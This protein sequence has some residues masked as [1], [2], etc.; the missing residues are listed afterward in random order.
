MIPD[1][2]KY[3]YFELLDSLKSI[4]RVAYPERVELIEKE[5]E[6]VRHKF[7]FLGIP[8]EGFLLDENPKSFWEKIKDAFSGD[9][10]VKV[11]GNI[12]AYVSEDPTGKFHASS[13]AAYLVEDYGNLNLVLRGSYQDSV[14]VDGGSGEVRLKINASSMKRLKE[15]IEQ[16]ESDINKKDLTSGR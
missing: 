14:Y 12:D 8:T 11:Y 3:T 10:P 16:V 4:D 9:K 15:V 2:S 7:P 1:F 5:L 6:L 13:V